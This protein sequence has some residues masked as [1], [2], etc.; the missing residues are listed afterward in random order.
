MRRLLLS[1]TMM[2]LGL[3]LFA[4]SAELTGRV[5]PVSTATAAAYRID[6]M[7]L[8]YPAHTQ[9]RMATGWDLR[10]AQTL[11]TN[12]L[13]F[14]GDIDFLPDERA[15]AVIG[16]SYIESSMLPAAQRVGHQLQGLLGDGQPVYAMGTPGAMLLDYAQSMRYASQKLQ[17]RDFVVFLSRG[18]IRQS[19]CTDRAACLDPGTMT[20]GS[21]RR[22][23]AGAVKQVLRESALAQYLFSQLRVSLAALWPA[24]KALPA[25]ALPRFGEAARADPA[26]PDPPLPNASLT[27]VAL[28]FFNQVQDLPLRT[29]VFVVNSPLAGETAS[30]PDLEIRQFGQLAQARGH[31]VVDMAEAFKAH[32]Q[33]SKLSLHVGPYDHHLNGLGP[34][35]VAQA[36]ADGLRRARQAPV[37]AAPQR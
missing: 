4:V 18:D 24:V 21:Y 13:G 31:T 26:P 11:R 22:D 25:S 6:P 9:V 20:L 17:V 23:D 8:T 5:L 10:N 35:L 32:A 12:N 29:L 7:I 36:A 3:A 27:A 14:V 28:R 19:V 1:L 15:V 2:A 37:A 33:G 30:E 34:G 16:D